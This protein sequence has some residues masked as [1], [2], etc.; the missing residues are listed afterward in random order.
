[1]LGLNLNFASSPLLIHSNPSF[2]GPLSKSLI[3]TGC[4]LRIPQEKDKE[5]SGDSSDI[6]YLDIYA[7]TRPSGSLRGVTK[8]WVVCSNKFLSCTKFYSA[9][10]K[11]QDDPDA[12]FPRFNYGG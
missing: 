10:E 11:I 1:M 2:A 12:V 8:L 6:T 7:T 5:S 3:I 9:E 4:H